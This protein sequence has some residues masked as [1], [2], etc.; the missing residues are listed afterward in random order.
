[1]INYLKNHPI[2]SVIYTI[3]LTPVLMFVVYPGIKLINYAHLNYSGYCITKGR[4]FSDE[5]RI[6]IAINSVLR[7][8]P[9]IMERRQSGMLEF[10]K[11]ENPIYYEDIEEFLELNENCCEVTTHG[12]EGYPRG[13]WNR[14]RGRTAVFV[15]VNYTVYYIDEDGIEREFKH[16]PYIAI[17]NCGR[18]WNGI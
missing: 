7:S 14:L 11:I 3:I 16:S 9:P 18:P 12:K 1:M 10:I 17:S 4:Y 8:Y 13:L 2:R 6:Q 5:E 15:S